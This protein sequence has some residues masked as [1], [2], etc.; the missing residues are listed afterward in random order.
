MKNTF[1][2]VTMTDDIQI[3]NENGFLIWERWDSVGLKNK[4]NCI[5]IIGRERG[6]VSDGQQAVC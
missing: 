4:D 3:Q 2:D 5:G 6:R 1:S